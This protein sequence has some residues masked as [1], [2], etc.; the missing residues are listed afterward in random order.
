M[1]THESWGRYP[2]SRPARVVDL[3]WTDA[4]LPADDRLLAYGLGRSYGDVPLNNGHTL[5]DTSRLNR[6]RGFD[7]EPIEVRPRLRE[8]RLGGSHTRLGRKPRSRVERRGHGGRDNSNR[9]GPANCIARTHVDPL[10]PPR[11]RCRHDESAAEP[12]LPFLVDGHTKWA[13][14]DLGGVDFDRARP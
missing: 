11:D 8:R 5:L 13:A 4:A 9:L 1:T 2:P 14:L 6:F 12:R 10:H 7:G 3:T